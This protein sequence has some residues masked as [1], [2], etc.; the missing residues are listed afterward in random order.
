MDDNKWSNGDSIVVINFISNLIV[1]KQMVRG[2][3]YVKN[4][5]SY[6][7]LNKSQLISKTN[8]STV[9][10]FTATLMLL[11]SPFAI[12]EAF[13]SHLSDELKWQLVFISSEPACTNYH[14]QMTNVYHDITA[15]YMELYQLEESSYDPLC[16]PEKKY[17]SDYESPRD[18][19]LIILVYDRNLG[20]KEL[21]GNQMGGL[22]THSGL[23]RTQNH[24]II[25]CDCA[26]F[27]YSPPS[28]ILSHELSHFTLYYKDYEMSVIED[29]IHVNDSKYDQCF[30][31]YI[32]QCKSISTKMEAGPAR[33]SYSVMPVYSPAV[34]VTSAN[35]KIYNV[36]PVVS[37]LSKVITKWWATGKISDGDYAN[38][39]GYVV[40][41][42]VLSSH[43][44]FTIMMADDPIDP[45]ITWDVLLEQTTP[46]YW[47]RPPIVEDKTKEMLSRIPDNLFSDDKELFS[48]DGD[49]GLPEWFKNTAEWWAND[50]ITNNEFKK[51]VEYLIESGV[52]QSHTS[53][54][55]QEFIKEVESNSNFKNTLGI[56]QKLVDEETPV[57][58]TTNQKLVEEEK[59]QLIQKDL[60]LIHNTIEGLVDEVNS[61]V[62]NEDLAPIRAKALIGK[63][64]TSITNFDSDKPTEGCNFLDYFTI[65]V[66]YFVETDKLTQT[67]GQSLLSSAEQIKQN[68]C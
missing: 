53:K 68:Y 51:N 57:V 60:S 20:E 2:L 44:D 17:L 61:T 45:T 34:G 39:I 40:D 12:N 25:I 54:V 59:K 50:E 19:D 41:N 5:I 21:H 30:E 49:F 18:L 13:A 10:L 42:S 28:W 3:D 32:E 26:N 14:Y 35:E 56:D 15:K 66:D 36:H 6:S 47:D 55:L 38:A 43:E 52:I 23:D 48:G 24:A 65:Q 9:V 67:S 27:Y 11:T 63:L 4:N 46:R 58:E 31:N 33:Y 62:I 22:Y 7:I 37:E 8:L 1:S 16:F 64:N 29:V